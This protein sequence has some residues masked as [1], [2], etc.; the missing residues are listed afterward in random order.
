MLT[1]HEKYKDLK[2]CEVFGSLDAFGL[3][4]W[5]PCYVYAVDQSVVAEINSVR[6]WEIIV[7]SIALNE[8]NE[9]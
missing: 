7:W 3:K 2:P 5:E 6:V 1:Y 4:P 9:F 8:S